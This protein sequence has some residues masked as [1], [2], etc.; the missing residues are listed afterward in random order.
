MNYGKQ[1]LN[2]SYDCRKSLIISLLRT[3]K[4]A[5]RFCSQTMCLLSLPCLS[6]VCLASHISLLL[7]TSVHIMQRIEEHGGAGGYVCPKHTSA[8]LLLL[9]NV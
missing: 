4:L 2:L 9:I 3:S 1:R 6:P 8:S 7:L 5:H